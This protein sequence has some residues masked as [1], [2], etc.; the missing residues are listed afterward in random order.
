MEDDGESATNGHDEGEEED[1]EVMDGYDGLEDVGSNE[2]QYWSVEVIEYEAMAG[3]WGEERF[4]R[5]DVERNGG[6][7]KVLG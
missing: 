3:F 6:V 7:Y 5:D 1:G 4:G 2:S